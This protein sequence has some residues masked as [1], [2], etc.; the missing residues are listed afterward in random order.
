[1]NTVCTEVVRHSPAYLSMEKLVGEDV[2][3]KVNFLLKV[4]HP[5]AGEQRMPAV[6]ISK[7]IPCTSYLHRNDY[8]AI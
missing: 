4:N 1:M 3:L 5:L 8:N 7:K 2:P 6:R